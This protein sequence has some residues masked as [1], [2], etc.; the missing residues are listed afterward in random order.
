MSWWIKG[1]ASHLRRTRAFRS[2][3]AVAAAI[4]GIAVPSLGAGVDTLARELTRAERRRRRREREEDREERDNRDNRDDRNTRDDADDPTDGN[5]QSLR[6]LLLE[7]FQEGGRFSGSDIANGLRTRQGGELRSAQ[8]ENGRQRASDAA[9]D[10]VN[11]LTRQDTQAPPQTA[12]DSSDDSG[13]ATGTGSAPST[14]TTPSTDQS[15][16]GSPESAPSINLSGG[17]SSVTIDFQTGAVVATSGDNTASVQNGVATATSNGAT[18]TAGPNGI[19]IEGGDD[20]GDVGTGDDTDGDDTGGDD[21][22][23]DNDDDQL[24]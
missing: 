4:A 17:S 10:E 3:Q 24:S 13:V 14:A 18:V 15:T 7:R 21:T 20:T 9:D 22:G 12:G 2:G 23:G 19:T 6:A 16:I 1:S 8:G 5:E 11:R